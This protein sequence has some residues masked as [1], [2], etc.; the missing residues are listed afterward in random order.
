[1][2]LGNNCNYSI[3][4]TTRSI[5]PIAN[6]PADFFVEP[7]EKVIF[8]LKTLEEHGQTIIEIDI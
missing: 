1:M 5:Q 2:T 8:H 4:A 3:K 6:A 7:V